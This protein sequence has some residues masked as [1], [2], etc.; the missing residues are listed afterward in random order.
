VGYWF[1]REQKPTPGQFGHAPEEKGYVSGTEV[2]AFAGQSVVNNFF[3]PSA[4]AYAVEYRRGL[5]A[6]LDGTAALI[7]EGDPELVRRSG[8]AIQA[9]AVNTWFRDQISVGI[10]F[11]PYLYIDRR[12][13]I[14]ADRSN[15]RVLP[16]A[17]LTIAQR[18]SDHLVARLIFHRVASNYNRDADILLLGLGWQWA[19]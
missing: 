3:S 4:R 14:Q 8:L 10:G 2:T 5:L 1:G 18:I 17:S 9:W 7:Y 12:H 6:H 19:R 16:L 13:V 11:G 15:P